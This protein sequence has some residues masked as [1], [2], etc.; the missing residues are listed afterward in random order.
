V[1]KDIKKQFQTSRRQSAKMK[2]I[3]TLYFTEQSAI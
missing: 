3:S 1:K 2:S